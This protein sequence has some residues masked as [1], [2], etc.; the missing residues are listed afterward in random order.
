MSAGALKE[1]TRMG[2][3]AKCPLAQKPIPFP[4]WYDNLCNWFVTI[5][6]KMGGV[7]W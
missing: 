2:G 4:D 1:R 5:N 7:T 6:K 3:G